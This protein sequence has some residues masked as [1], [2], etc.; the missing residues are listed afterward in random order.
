MRPM[1]DT[2][3]LSLFPPHEKLFGD[4][5]DALHA[6]MRRFPRKVRWG[7]AYREQGYVLWARGEDIGEEQFAA[8][9]EERE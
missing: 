7:V 4:D 8:T 5:T 9:V 3:Q 6:A 2:K 1:T